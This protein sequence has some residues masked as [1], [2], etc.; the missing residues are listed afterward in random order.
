MIGSLYPN[1]TLPFPIP[2]FI[3]KTIVSYFNDFLVLTRGMQGHFSWASAV[4]SRPHA[5]GSYKTL[6]L[7][8]APRAKCQSTP[9]Q[10]TIK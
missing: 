3:D 4:G 1:P 7:S 5:F 8:I 10:L 2:I 6:L 9:G